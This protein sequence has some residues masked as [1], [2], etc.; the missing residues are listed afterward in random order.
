MIILYCCRITSHPRPTLSLSPSHSHSLHSLS[1][2]STLSPLSPSL[3]PPSPSTLPPPLCLPI[4][5]PFPFSLQPSLSLSP[6][7]CPSLSLSPLPFSPSSLSLSLSSSLYSAVN[8]FTIMITAASSHAILTFCL[9]MITDSL[10]NPLVN[11]S[12]TIAFIYNA[13]KYLLSVCMFT[14]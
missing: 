12:E 1:R 2:S 7:L 4:S 13:Y 6:S 5:L 10:D 11:C 3:S 14:K 8:L 9:E